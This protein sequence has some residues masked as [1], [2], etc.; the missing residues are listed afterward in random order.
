MTKSV[1]KV[2]SI[3]KS[4]KLGSITSGTLSQDLSSFWY[5]LLKKKIQTQK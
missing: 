4:Y 1:L 5:K 3:S 2:K